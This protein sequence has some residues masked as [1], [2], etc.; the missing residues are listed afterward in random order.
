M[1]DLE[2]TGEAR[3]LVTEAI[4]DVTRQETAIATQRAASTGQ[5][6]RERAA[7]LALVVTLPALAIVLALHFGG[8]TL[9][10]LLTPRPSP[11]VARQQAE[12]TLQSLVADIEAF[13]ED[14]EELPES[15]AEVGIPARG[16]WQYTRTD[17]GSFTLDGTLD[18][19]RVSFDSRRSG[20]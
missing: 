10:A 4:D 8:P 3:Q 13:R 15:L 14:Y 11:E 6:K 5:R 1:T 7:R 9:A 17:G 2:S 19:E 20:L 16:D 18:G 12:Q